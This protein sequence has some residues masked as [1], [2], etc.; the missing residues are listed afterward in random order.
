M[1]HVLYQM[2]YEGK[3]PEVVTVPDPLLVGSASEVFEDG[4][5]VGPA[6]PDGLTADHPA[7]RLPPAG[8]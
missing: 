5:P 6:L 8:W 2:P 7:W 3:D 1:R 4:D